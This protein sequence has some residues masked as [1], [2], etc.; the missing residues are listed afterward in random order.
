MISSVTLCAAT[1]ENLAPTIDALGLCLDAC[2]FGDALLCG[3]VHV[4]GPFRHIQIDPW[5]K[6]EDASL[7]GLK[8]LHKHIKTSHVL[9]IQWDSWI[10]NPGVW[11][12]DFLRYD[13]IGA[14]WPWYP[15]HRVGNGGFCLR[16]RALLDYLSEIPIEFEPKFEDDTYTCRIMRPLLEQQGFKFAP[17]SVADIFSYERRM[18]KKP[19]FGFHGLFNCWRHMED[20][21]FIKMVEK[22][23]NYVILGD[24]FLETFTLYF[25]MRKFDVLKAMYGRMRHL[26]NETEAKLHIGKFMHD[27]NIT[28]EAFD[29]CENLISSQS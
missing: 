2:D 4:D 18:P 3:P 13:Y 27:P 5:N 15:D 10:I 28:D 20:R 1:T 9:C 17:E 26:L 23:S 22:L 14:T 16:S 24:Q 25:A 19:T 12:D 29:I 11:T 6:R 7:F 21:E 8:E